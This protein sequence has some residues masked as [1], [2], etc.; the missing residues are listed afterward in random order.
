MT[1]GGEPTCTEYPFVSVIIPTKNEEALIGNGLSS[2]KDLDYP[3]E[4]LEI[5]IADGLS[6]DRTA[7]IAESYGAEVVLD[8][9]KSVASGRNAAFAVARGELI[10]I[11]DADCT[12][13]RNWLKNCLK[14]FQD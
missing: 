14:Y 10:A 6:S 4:R 12:M 1:I 7:E 9:R 11:S 13:D 5:I 8:H 3:P 2:L